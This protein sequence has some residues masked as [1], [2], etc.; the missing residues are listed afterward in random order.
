MEGYYN[1][2]EYRIIRTPLSS[3][4]LHV[5]YDYCHIKPYDCF[6]INTEDDSYFCYPKQKNV[7]TKI[8]FAVE[9]IYQ[10]HLNKTKE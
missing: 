9:A 8:G 10:H 3:N 6:V 5:E 1:N 2:Q 7:I 4:S